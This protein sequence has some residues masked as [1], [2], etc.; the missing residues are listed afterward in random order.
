MAGVVSGGFLYLN[1]SPQL[2]PHL[3]GTAAWL[4]HLLLLALA[5]VIG[6]RVLGRATSPV[7]LILAPLS[8][9]AAKR[10]THTLFSTFRHPT[11][12]LRLLFSLP[13]L[14]LLLY[15][16]WRIGLQV[17]AGLDPNFTVNAWGG[18]SYLGALACHYL[19]AALLIAATAALL[20]RLLLPAPP[21]DNTR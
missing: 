5:L 3:D 13:L 4:P 1:R 15:S 21:T 11:A 12:L 18:P 14:A 16:P 6:H 7:Q 19:D 10:L 20:N 17:L 8:T 2:E 9:S